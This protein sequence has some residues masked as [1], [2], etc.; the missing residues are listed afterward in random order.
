MVATAEFMYYRNQTIRGEGSTDGATVFRGYFNGTIPI[1][2]KRYQTF[3]QKIIKAVQRDLEVLSSPDNRHPNFIRYFGH[4]KDN[5][6][7]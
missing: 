4:A 7:R 3:D 5:D 6:F 1:A 2:L